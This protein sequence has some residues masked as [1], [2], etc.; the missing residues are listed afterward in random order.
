MTEMQELSDY[1]QTVLKEK[2]AELAK[3][4]QQLAIAVEALKEYGNCENWNNIYDSESADFE[5]LYWA[6]KW[7]DEYGYKY[8]QEKLKQIEELNK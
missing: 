4:K 1:F 3:V 8:A 7:K 2:K 5:P 6:N